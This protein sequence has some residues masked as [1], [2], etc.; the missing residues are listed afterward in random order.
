M[1]TVLLVDDHALV[2]SGLKALIEGFAGFRVAGEAADGAAGLSMAAALRPD[3]VLLD[4]SLPG[5]NGFDTCRALIAQ[6]GGCK[7]LMLS[8]HAGKVYVQEAL[9]AGASGYIVKDAVPAALEC[10]LRRVAAGG[11]Y[12][13]EAHDAVA[14]GYGEG[15][16]GGFGGGRCGED[17]LTRRQREILRLV[18]EG[19]TTRQIAA[20][21][22]I[23]IKTVETHR[24]QLMQRLGI[25][26]VAG[27]TRYAIRNG[28]VSPDA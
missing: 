2:R 22:F 10:A 13:P 20:Q 1:K 28:L 14:H 17:G 18:A 9:R 8:M 5:A 11:Q 24:A 16:D 7:V 6:S 3:I 27:L 4:V 19:H 12:L 21:L 23:S 26:D 25:F 15:L